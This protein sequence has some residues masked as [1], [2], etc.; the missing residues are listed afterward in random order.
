VGSGARARKGGREE[1]RGGSTVE[2]RKKERTDGRCQGGCTYT[3][4]GGGKKSRRVTT[5]SHGKGTK[6]KEVTSFSR[7][8]RRRTKREFKNCGRKKGGA[9]KRQAKRLGNSEKS[10]LTE[11]ESEVK[12]GESYA[13]SHRRRS[14]RA[15][16]SKQRNEK[17]AG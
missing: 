13:C 15:E 11:G 16:W 8:G 3:Y 2:S 17:G 14:W 5:G 7:R 9:R 4:K 12:K 1:A 10:H 6:Q